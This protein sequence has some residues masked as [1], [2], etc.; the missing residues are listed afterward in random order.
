MLLSQANPQTPQAISC[1][2]KRCAPLMGSTVYAAGAIAMAIS[3]GDST[4][5]LRGHVTVSSP[6]PFYHDQDV[7]SCLVPLVEQLRVWVRGSGESF[8]P[9]TLGGSRPIPPFGAPM[10]ACNV[11]RHGLAQT[12]LVTLV[13]CLLPTFGDL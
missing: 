3:I 2:A 6:S 11:D 13:S 9:G 12:V 1:S 7:S 8:R 5:D 4:T 10:S